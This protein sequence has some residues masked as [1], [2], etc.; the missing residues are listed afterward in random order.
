M[1]PL[2]TALLAMTLIDSL[3]AHC[4]CRHCARL[5]STNANQ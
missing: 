4:C 2:A 1:P 5:L 3:V